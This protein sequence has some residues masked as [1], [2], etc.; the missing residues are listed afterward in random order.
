MLALPLRDRE[1]L[2]AIRE[3]GGTAVAKSGD[4]SLPALLPLDLRGLVMATLT[5]SGLKSPL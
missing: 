2:Q 4:A 1:I 3:T 5:G